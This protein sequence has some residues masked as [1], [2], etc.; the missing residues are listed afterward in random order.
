MNG[1]LTFHLGKKSCDDKNRNKLNK[2]SSLN[3]NIQYETINSGNNKAKSNRQNYSLNND[4]QKT[5]S[6]NNLNN[7]NNSINI[8]NKFKKIPLSKKIDKIPNKLI[9][10]NTNLR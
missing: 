6:I 2:N 1:N 10:S 3:N 4:K 7:L 5:L 9:F 8:A